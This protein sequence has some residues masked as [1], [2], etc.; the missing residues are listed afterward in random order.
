[1]GKERA[2]SVCKEC[3]GKRSTESRD[4]AD[5]RKY[6]AAADPAIGRRNMQ[7]AAPAEDLERVSKTVASDGAP[8]TNQTATDTGGSDGHVARALA[9]VG[10]GDGEQVGAERNVERDGEEAALRGQPQRNNVDARRSR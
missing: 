8:N 5:G 3:E 9:D 1:M 10:R 7:P 4:E 2:R 6:E